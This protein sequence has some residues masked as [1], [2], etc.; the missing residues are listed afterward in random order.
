MILIMINM[1]ILLLKRAC[2]KLFSYKIFLVCWYA[3]YILLLD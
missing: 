1:N 3:Q 2:N